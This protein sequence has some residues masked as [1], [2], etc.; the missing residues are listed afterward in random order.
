MARVFFTSVLLLSLATLTLCSEAL[1]DSTKI[2]EYRV[3][4]AYL[5]NF[6][7]FVDWPSSDEENT[8]ITIAI[9]G[10]DIPKLFGKS[11]KE[12]QTKKFRNK[13]IQIVTLHPKTSAQELSSARIVFFTSSARDTQK[14]LLES[15]QH[16]S[17]LTIGETSDFLSDG[18]M[19]TFVKGENKIR[20]E[21]NLSATEKAELRIPSKVKRLALRIV[22]AQK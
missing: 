18:G 14:T 6:L 7:R 9:I 20:F 19:I 8:E 5:L 17:I 2:P 16:D 11:L 10:D 15:I 13:Q 1:G 22:N 21:L 3:K 4:A 12:L